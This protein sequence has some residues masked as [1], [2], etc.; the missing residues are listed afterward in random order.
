MNGLELWLAA[1]GTYLLVH[2]AYCLFVYLC[3]GDS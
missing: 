3:G 2:G 1:I